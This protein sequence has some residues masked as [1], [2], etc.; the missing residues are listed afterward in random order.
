MRLLAPP[1]E[2]EVRLRRTTL[3][4]RLERDEQLLI[5]A[6]IAIFP[7]EDS[8]ITQQTLLDLLH[9]ISTQTFSHDSEKLHRFQQLVTTL[10]HQV[11][12]V[13]AVKLLQSIPIALK[14]CR[15]FKR[16]PRQS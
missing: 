11:Q 14:K 7:F 2:I 13:N 12:Q 1:P 15:S 3:T 9:Q 4:F 10:G 16:P 6:Y 5:T 8:K